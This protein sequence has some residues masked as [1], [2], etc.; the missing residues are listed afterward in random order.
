[1]GTTLRPSG[2]VAAVLHAVLLARRAWPADKIS[3]RLIARDHRHQRC[4]EEAVAMSSLWRAFYK[5]SGLKQ[6]YQNERDLAALKVKAQDTLQKMLTLK[7]DREMRKKMEA[8][9]LMEH[10]R[11]QLRS[12][13]AMEAEAL[14]AVKERRERPWTDAQKAAAANFHSKVGALLEK[15][16]AKDE[17]KLEQQ[18]E[19]LLQTQPAMLEKLKKMPSD[20]QVAALEKLSAHNAEPHPPDPPRRDSGWLEAGRRLLPS[21]YGR[22]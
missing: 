15:K 10:L 22:L 21:G 7:E 1:M 5:W 9:L 17:K 19:M 4:S 18:L 3:E 12:M 14:K 13:K 16:Q 8:E 11:K 2:S 6:Y 20:E